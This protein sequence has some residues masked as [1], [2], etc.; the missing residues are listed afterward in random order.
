MAYKLEGQLHRYIGL[1]TDEK[2]TTSVAAPVGS[3]FFESDTGRMYRWNG[4]DWDFPKGV[5]QT[6]SLLVELIFEVRAMRESI[7]VLVS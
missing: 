3:T 5:S 4:S 2:P 7:E 6:D 1:S